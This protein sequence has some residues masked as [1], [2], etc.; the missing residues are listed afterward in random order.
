M[1]PI[2]TT[3]FTPWLSLFGGALIGLSA[4]MVM[5]LFGKIAGIT[6][7]TKGLTGLM[8][9]TDGPGDRGW[10]LSFLLGLIV[11]PIAVLLVTG[12]FPQQSVSD[13]FT[14]MAIAG[15]LVGTGTALGSGCTS[16]HGVCGLARMSPR[17]LAAVGMFV[18]AAI[19]T[20]TL[21]RHVF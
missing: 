2:V 17:S 5:G 20:T 19:V 3:E 16:G 6:G 4:V 8:P 13:N 10:R 9:W 21:I 18:A 11:A 14:G 12:S 7:I 15:L 1:G